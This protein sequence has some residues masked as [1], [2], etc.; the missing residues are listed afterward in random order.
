M[1][2]FRKNR[3]RVLIGMLVM[4]GG[5][6]PVCAEE[7]LSDGDENVFEEIVREEI[8][9]SESEIF[10]ALSEADLLTGTDGS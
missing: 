4:L 1:L 10:T 8:P 6:S 9:G 5:L 7:S 2:L 3:A